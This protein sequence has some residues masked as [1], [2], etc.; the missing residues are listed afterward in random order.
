MV[1]SLVAWNKTLTNWR[2]LL[3]SKP[4]PKVY[5]YRNPISLLDKKKQC[6]LAIKRQATEYS[7]RSETRYHAQTCR[8]LH[9]PGTLD[10]LNKNHWSESLSGKATM[11]K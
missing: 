3:L 9:A 8:Q 6:H 7:V 1:L 10:R 11:T 2:I 4:K 5:T